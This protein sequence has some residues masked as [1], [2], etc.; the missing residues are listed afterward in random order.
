MA[1][2]DFFRGERDDEHERDRWRSMGNDWRDED[3][4]G[5]NQGH[6]YRS[7]ERDHR[8]GS[9]RNWSPGSEYYSERSQTYRGGEHRDEDWGGSGGQSGRNWPG[10]SGQHWRDRDEAQRSYGSQGEGDYGRH[11]GEQ[12]RGSGSGTYGRYYGGGASGYTGS[13]F[14]SRGS[15]SDYGRGGYSGYSSGSFGASGYGSRETSG[16]GTSGYGPSSYG[17]GYGSGFESS[18]NWDQGAQ[19]WSGEHRGKGPRGYRRS[20]ER[21][22]EEVCD[23]LTDDP[24]IDASNIEVAVKECEVTLS[25]SVSSREDKRRAEDLIERL[26]GVKDVTNNLRVMQQQAEGGQTQTENRASPS[27]KH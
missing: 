2:R 10:S 11:G 8:G 15:E 9:E 27:A 18:R 17:Q 13:D 21:I 23:C 12:G 16:R 3:R 14:G 5:R 6:E 20:D 4:G 22:K 25:G 19:Q 24:R 7:A 26:S 1:F